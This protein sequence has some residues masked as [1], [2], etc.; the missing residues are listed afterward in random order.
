M[1]LAEATTLANDF[2]TALGEGAATM[3][4]APFAYW[5]NALTKDY[6]VVLLPTVYDVQFEAATES[7]KIAFARV[8]ALA[9]SKAPADAAAFVAEFDLQGA[10]D[11]EL[12]DYLGL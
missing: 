12:A 4:Y 1:K 11:A 8:S 3:K 10:Q 9:I 2:N 5:D 6:N 7:Q